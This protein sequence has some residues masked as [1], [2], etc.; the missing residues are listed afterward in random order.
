[1]RC[2]IDELS[3]KLKT[4]DDELNKSREMYRTLDHKFE[5]T[6]SDMSTQI[7]NLVSDVA[8]KADNIDKLN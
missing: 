2:K 4:T 1:M 6:R 5:Y 3:Y 8:K 7:N